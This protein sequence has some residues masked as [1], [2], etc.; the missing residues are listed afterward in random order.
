[1]FHPS[2][3][4]MYLYRRAHCESLSIGACVETAEFY[5]VP[6]AQFA[7]FLVTM[8]IDAQRLALLA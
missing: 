1:M 7:R 6:V 8:G 4:R 2:I 3:L 5:D